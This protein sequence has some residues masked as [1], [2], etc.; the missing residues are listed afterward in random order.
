[1]KTKRIAEL[2]ALVAA[3]LLTR[4]AADYQNAGLAG[5]AGE[6]EYRAEM[7]SGFVWIRQG[8]AAWTG[9]YASAAASPARY[10]DPDVLRARQSSDAVRSLILRAAPKPGG[11]AKVSRGV[12]HSSPDS[13]TARHNRNS[14]TRGAK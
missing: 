4:A 6:M 8:K 9:N 1:M 12:S 10:G 7:V 2:T 5:E 14:K 3:D 11:R 13:K